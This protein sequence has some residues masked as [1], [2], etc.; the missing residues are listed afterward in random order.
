MYTPEFK[1]LSVQTQALITD[2]WKKHQMFIQQAQMQ[3]M[4]MAEAVKGT[5]GQKGQASQPTF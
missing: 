5:P 2:H 4:Q 3:A 1:R